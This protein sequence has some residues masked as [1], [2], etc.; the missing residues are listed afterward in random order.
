MP[1]AGA[2]LARPQAAVHA[3]ELHQINDGMLPIEFLWIFRSQI[4]ENGGDI[5][6][7]SGGRCAAS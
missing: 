2:L 4:I 1:L 5:D 7:L 3:Y 6:R